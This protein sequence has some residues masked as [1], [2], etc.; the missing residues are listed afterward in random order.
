MASGYMGLKYTVQKT[1][2]GK[3]VNPECMTWSCPTDLV[4]KA[5]ELGFRFWLQGCSGR[6]RHNLGR[7][8]IACS[9]RCHRNVQS[10][11]TDVRSGS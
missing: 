1:V 10:T 11:Q 6:Y 5:C 2:K 3:R 9:H 4:G 8:T 7:K